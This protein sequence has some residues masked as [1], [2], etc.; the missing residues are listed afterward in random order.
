[1][2]TGEIA[3]VVTCFN[4]GR[5]LEESLAS[6]A[7]QTRAPTEIVI[8]DDGSDDVFT[9]QILASVSRTHDVVRT[10]NRGVSAARNL[11]IRRTHAQYIVLLDA[12]DLLEPTYLEKAAAVLDSRPELSFVSCG[13]KSFGLMEEVWFPPSPN[14]TESLAHGVVHISSMFRRVLWETV[15]GFDEHLRA[16]EEVDFWT[17]A[18]AQGFNGEVLNE[19]LVRYRIRAGS[20]YR[21]AIRRDAHVALMRRLY[22]KHRP[23]LDAH[24][25]PLL[26]AKE[27]F[28]EE[29]RAHRD[30][31]LATAQTA[32]NQLAALNRDIQSVVGELQNLGRR[33]GAVDFGDLRRTTPISPVWGI[34]RGGPIDRYYIAQFLE[35]HRSDIRGH[36]LEIKDAG[37]TRRFGGD[38]VT[39]VDVLDID[40]DNRN[41]T[42]IA[43][44]SRASNVR[45]EQFDC[46]ILTQTLGLIFDVELA[47]IHVHRLLKP[48]GVLLC[49]LPASG[50][51]SF[52]GAGLDG[53]FWRFTEAGLRRL[54]SPLF[55]VEACEVTPFGNV[56][57][58]AAF[59]YGLSPDELSSTE[60]DALDPY[61]PVVYGV[62]AARPLP[63]LS[64]TGRRST[65]PAGVILMYHRIA[66]DSP[67]PDALCVS[68]A[69]FRSQ[70][71]YLKSEGY[72]VVPLRT[73]ADA[74]WSDLPDRAV[75]LTFDDGYEDALDTA[76]PILR[77]FDFPATFFVG[78]GMHST[79][80]FWWDALAHVFYR[81]HTLPDRLTLALPGGDPLELPT[82]SP[83][84]RAIA[85]Q[86]IASACHKLDVPSRTA[87]LDAVL[88]WSGTDLHQ[89]A[90][91]LS[92]EQLLELARQPGI[93]I[94]C[95]SDAH[96]W[97]PGLRAG[98]L[99]AEV[100]DAKR[101][102]EDRLGILVS[103]FAY[104]Y[105]GHDGPAEAAV[106]EAGF[107]IAVTTAEGAITSATLPFVTPRLDARKYQGI[108]FAGR[109]EEL[110]GRRTSNARKA[111]TKRTLVAGWFSFAEGHATAG[112]VRACG[113]VRDWL[114][115]ANLSFD[116]AGVPPFEGDVDWRM[117]NPD[118]Y[119]QVIFVCG[120][121]AE[122]PE[123]ELAF[124]ERFKGRRLIGL[125]L[126]MLPDLST[127]NPF[128]VLLERDSSRTARPDVVFLAPT[129]RVPV[130]GTCLVEASEGANTA[131]AEAAFNRLS[132]SQQMALVSV[133]TR[134]DVNSTGLRN[135]DEIES[136]I[137]KVDVLLTTRLHG[138][139]FALK[140]GV[141]AVA[142][143]VAPAVSK[144]LTQ[145]RV[146]GWPL[147]YSVDAITD[148]VLRRAFEYCLT[149]AS[150]RLAQEVA[151]R[152][153]R[154]LDAVR[155][156][157]IAAATKPC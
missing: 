5:T 34:D 48:G 21:S 115:S 117:V 96:V 29:Q 146:I 50:R 111:A 25:R 95:H 15:G 71:R 64:M 38:G 79:A 12:D 17:G 45:S 86:R 144:L 43:D 91:P 49:T 157:F 18:L 126:S 128:D 74:G 4:L 27:R 99:H 103:S 130:V 137:A 94:G 20:L 123:L 58:C 109:M 87:V 153:A 122:G 132:Q 145:A 46:I 93:S 154:E 62:R 59:L 7:R 131:L 73:F 3:V 72:T 75:A 37:Y 10:E 35:R 119:A 44:L 90:R 23:T 81:T 2:S 116:V 110:F 92:N 129:K 67:D 85:H 124:L 134:L 32:R 77:E 152:A 112:D 40:G 6:V 105:G 66:D 102:L 139:V 120:P 54:F 9:R 70:L 65:D 125:N 69:E 140:N 63:T 78:S 30:H 106:R 147:V 138:L 133:D 148:D 143:D 101:R 68:P 127:W 28:I 56:L 114:S 39:R 83:A 16:H 142:I 151:S 118:D 22:E 98:R 61:F 149:P 24:V 33:D 8:V 150:R 31:L 53:D 156:D 52:E 11:G 14:L 113:L 1:V 155:L 47:L 88:D 107:Q 19:P 57:A 26:L 89:C 51:L 41:A 80:E 97:L 136:V 121:F 76:S 82:E 104:P 13:M 36:V 60:L 84:E 108:E 135:A 55:P 42:I 141:P 100:V